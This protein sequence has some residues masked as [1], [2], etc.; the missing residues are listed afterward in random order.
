MKDDHMPTPYELGVDPEL[1]V[2]AVLDTALEATA[3]A[4]ISA[5]PSLCDDERPPS[6]T[7][8][9]VSAYRLLQSANKLQTAI[10][11]YREA[12][13]RQTPLESGGAGDHDALSSDAF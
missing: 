4:L 8:P 5:Y 10:A 3:R 6:K 9:D 2:L 12:L 7:E 13:E 1:A 11:R